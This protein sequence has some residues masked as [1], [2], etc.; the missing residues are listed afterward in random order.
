MRRKIMCGN[1]GRITGQLVLYLCTLIQ[2]GILWQDWSCRTSEW[3]FGHPEISTLSE[4]LFL[5]V[6]LETA[7]LAGKLTLERKR[8]ESLVALCT[9]NT[10]H[11]VD[12]GKKNSLWE[13]VW[14]CPPGWYN[15]SG[16]VRNIVASCIHII[17][18]QP[19]WELR[20]SSWVRHPKKLINRATKMFSEVR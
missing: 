2:Y 16:T 13:D 3:Q 5:E 19:D 1:C 11:P 9:P 8:N 4:D 18:N 12:W 15:G 7:L 20:T 6:S 10:C 17:A 14:H